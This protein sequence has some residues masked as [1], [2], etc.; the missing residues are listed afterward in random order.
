MTNI[1]IVN[2]SSD[3]D[4]NGKSTDSVVMTTVESA[5]LVSLD[6]GY[7]TKESSKSSTIGESDRPKYSPVY[8]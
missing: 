3:C 1:D 6:E 7:N 8:F 2:K 4:L 5:T